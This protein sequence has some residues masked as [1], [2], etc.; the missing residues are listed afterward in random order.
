MVTLRD[1]DHLPALLQREGINVRMFTDW[2]ELNKRD[3]AARTLTYAKIP[4]HYVWHEKQKPWKQRKQQK[5]IGRIVYSS[6]TSGERYYLQMLLNVVRGPKEFV[7][8]MT[9]NKRIY[10]T[11]KETCFAYGLLNDDKEW[12]HAISETSLWALGPQLRDLLVTI[13]IFCDSMRVNEYYD[14]GEI[15]TYHDFTTRQHD[16]D[17]LKEHPI[18]TPRNDDADANNAYTRPTQPIP[19]RVF[20]QLKLP[21]HATALSMLKEGTPH[22]AHTKR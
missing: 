12:T 15:D 7:E 10:P 1:S 5:C 20:E 6:P 13:L 4:K 21:R 18:L 2:F 11:F 14:N 19:G 22:H 17:Y 9:I 8:L 3:P 16:D